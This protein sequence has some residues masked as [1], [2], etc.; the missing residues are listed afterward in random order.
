M[1]ATAVIFVVSV[2]RLFRL[3]VYSAAVAL[4]FKDKNVSKNLPVTGQ[5]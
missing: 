3:P 5:V 2:S 4:G 1:P